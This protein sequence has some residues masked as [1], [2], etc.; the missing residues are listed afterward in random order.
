MR[1]WHSGTYRMDGTLSYAFEHRHWSI[2]ALK[3]THRVAI[4]Y[5]EGTIMVKLG[6]EDPIASMDPTGKVTWAR[7]NEIQQGRAPI[8]WSVCEKRAFRYI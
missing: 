4:G 8:V 3:G 6:R 1:L 7:H 5:D 2:C